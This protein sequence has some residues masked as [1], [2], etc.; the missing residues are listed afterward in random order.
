MT[1]DFPLTDAARE[2]ALVLDVLGDALAHPD[3]EAAT[4]CDDAIAAA[5]RRFQAAADARVSSGPPSHDGLVRVAASLARCR[6]LGAS[7]ARF[8]APPAS[9]ADTSSTYRP[10]GRGPSRRDGGGVLTARG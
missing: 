4:P 5:V 6:R 10:P 7:L 3:A 9:D 1:D 8:T 2:L